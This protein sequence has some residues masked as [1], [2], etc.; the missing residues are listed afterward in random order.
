MPKFSIISPVYLDTP[1]RV[2]QFLTCIQSVKNQTFKDFEWVI[3]DDGSVQP[4][5]WDNLLNGFD[6]NLIHKNNENRII[7]YNT[8]FQVA[9]G[10]WWIFLDSDDELRDCPTQKPAHGFSF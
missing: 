3:I 9:K 1:E 5:L 7:A 6:L 4:F 8:A 10:D 2:E